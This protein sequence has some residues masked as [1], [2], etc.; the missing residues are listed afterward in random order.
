MPKIKVYHFHNGN[1][2]GVLSVIRN[3]LKFSKDPSIENHV[4]YTINKTVTP[5]VEFLALEGAAS[6]QVFYYDP[7]WNFY[8]TCRQLAKLLPD[9]K[10]VIVAHDW[11][12]LGMAS[13]LGLQNAIVHV[14]HG[15]YEYYYDLAK[16]H[17]QSTDQFVTVSPVIYKKLSSILP[18]RIEDIQ[19]CRFPV[20][21][22]EA[23]EKQNPI[24]KIIYCVRSLDDANKQF[25]ILP[26]I[27][28]HLHAK[29]I[30]VNWTIIGEGISKPVVEN[31]MAQDTGISFFASLP[32]EEVTRLLPEHDLFILPSLQEGFP[33]TVVEAM[34]AGVV[35]L[36][37]NWGGS[38]DEV[39]IHGVTGYYFEAGHA[40]GYADTISMLNE[41]RNL[42]N[43][44]AKRGI[45]KANGL[46][47]P[48]KTQRK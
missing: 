46:F 2:G 21:S 37:T 43:K 13:N 12:E 44:L 4:I 26:A 15:N 38:T 39:V 31:L 1:G 32:N 27:N 9:D 8:Y 41:D 7:N 42:L 3:L 25:K 5:Q 36:V 33:V 34:K 20:P 35:P 28:A 6:Q 14:V 29:G 47:D 22:I 23:I 45:K 40:N 16:K 11:I 30:S 48:Q 18:E 10:A 24:L 17:E 19:Y